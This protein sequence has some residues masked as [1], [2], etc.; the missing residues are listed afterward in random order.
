MDFGSTLYLFFITNIDLS[1]YSKNVND[2]IYSACR[3]ASLKQFPGSLNINIFN[4]ACFVKKKK[5]EI[6]ASRQICVHNYCIMPHP[7]EENGV[8]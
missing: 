7:K 3:N 4:W 2:K 5:G 8:Y 1:F 6:L